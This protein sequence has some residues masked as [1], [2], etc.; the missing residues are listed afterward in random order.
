MAKQAE[1]DVK[2]LSEAERIKRS[3]ER[4]AAAKAEQERVDKLVRANERRI[5]A[6]LLGREKIPIRG[7]R[8]TK[9]KQPSKTVVRTD[10]KKPPTV[11]GA[12]KK[13]AGVLSGQTA[14][15]RI[16]RATE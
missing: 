2:T 13:A 5:G 15:E 12:L 3:K 9:P 14:R 4:L 6:R 10:P 16:R 7:G 8:F 11:G 1:A